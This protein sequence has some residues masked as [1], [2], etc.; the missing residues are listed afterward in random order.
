MRSV[1]ALAPDKP[2]FLY[3]APRTRHVEL[4]RRERSR[5]VR[6]HGPSREEIFAGTP[7][8]W[9]DPGSQFGAAMTDGAGQS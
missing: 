2:F 4:R 1:K 5:S 6:R 8:G 9:P 7:S 3:F